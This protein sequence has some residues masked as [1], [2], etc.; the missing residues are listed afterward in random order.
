MNNWLHLW[1]KLIV[2]FIIIHLL[3][4][5]VFPWFLVRYF[6]S[7]LRSWWNLIRNWDRIRLSSLQLC[8][9]CVGLF[10]PFASLTYCPKNREKETIKMANPVQRFWEK[11]RIGDMASCRTYLDDSRSSE[12]HT[13]RTDKTH[14][15]LIYPG[16]SSK[17]KLRANKLNW[18]WY[19]EHTHWIPL[20][21]NL[22]E[23][24]AGELGFHGLFFLFCFFILRCLILETSVQP[25]VDVNYLFCIDI[26]ISPVQIPTPTP[27]CES[28]PGATPTRPRAMWVSLK[29]QS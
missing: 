28:L 12:S 3:C 11:E 18:H 10:F 21:L 6:M 15:L 16:S 7:E 2:L 17:K 19:T 23:Y 8:T 29:S 13:L 14:T 26:K 20:E 1:L 9:F 24:W 22:P 4:V 27:F 25:A 5:I